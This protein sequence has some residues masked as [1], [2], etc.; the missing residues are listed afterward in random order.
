MI[1]KE[2]WNTLLDLLQEKGLLE[3]DL[4]ESFIGG[5]GKG[6]QKQNRTKNCVRLTHVP[7]KLSVTCQRGRSLDENRFFARR[8]LLE[9]YQRE[10]LGEETKKSQAIEKKKKQ[11]KRRARRHKKQLDD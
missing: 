4:Q 11:K 2:T 6:G 3:K 1:K 5:S 9:K 8:L 7:S 10:V